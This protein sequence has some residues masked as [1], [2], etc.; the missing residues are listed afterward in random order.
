MTT[1]QRDNMTLVWRGLLLAVGLLVLAACRAV[2][3]P[4]APA[5]EVPEPASTSDE[6]PAVTVETGQGGADVI[7]VTVNGAPGAYSF[8]VEVASPDTGCENYADWWE[9]VDIEGNLLYRRILTHSHVGEQP[10]TRSGG[11]VDIATDTVVWV[12]AHMAP[13][14]YGGAAMRGSAQDGFVP[15]QPPPDFA[16][17]LAGAAPQPTGCAF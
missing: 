2:V 7:A 10:F 1:G 11:P 16:A 14:G 15:A 17:G 4:A 5:A 8:A 3:A 13:G 6:Q 12:R 9:V